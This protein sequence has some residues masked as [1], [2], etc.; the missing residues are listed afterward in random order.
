MFANIENTVIIIPVFNAEKHLNK[1]LSE[2]LNYTKNIIVVDDGSTDKSGDI[3]KSFEII[4][5]RLNE[6][7][8]K[9]KALQKGFELAI[10]NGFKYALTLDSDYQHPPRDIKK[11]IKRQIATSADLVYG[12]RCFCPK[13]MPAHRIISNFLTSLIVSVKIGNPIYDSQSGYRLYRLDLIKKIELTTNRYQ[14]ETELI[15]KLA[16]IGAKFEFVPIETIYDDEK[17]YISHFRDIKNFI[18]VI[19]EKTEKI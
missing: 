1:L 18:K 11:F 5:H 3:C 14:T 15:I 4:Y 10:K 6:N 7:Q 8:G 16:K 12:K 13:Y 19:L 17:S 2:I 9:G